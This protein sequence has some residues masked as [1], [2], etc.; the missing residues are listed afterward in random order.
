MLWAFRE[1]KPFKRMSIIIKLI[2]NRKNV[3]KG[4]KEKSISNVSH[5]VERPEIFLFYFNKIFTFSQ[6]FHT[7]FLT[8]KKKRKKVSN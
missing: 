8:F 2:L 1:S 7:W 4:G 6:H 3:Q 5:L